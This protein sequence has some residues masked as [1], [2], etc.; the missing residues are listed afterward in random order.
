MMKRKFASEIYWPLAFQT[1]VKS[2]TK[3]FSNFVAFSEKPN[4]TWLY[5]KPSL[6]IR[7][8]SAIFWI[9]L[10]IFRDYALK[11]IFLFYKIENWNFQHLFKIEFLEIK[12]YLIIMSNKSSIN[13]WWRR[14]LLPIGST[15]VRLR[16]S[17]TD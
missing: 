7:T 2:T 17:L 16:R 13:F 10:G 8:A 1:F 9:Y 3:I 15:L 14:Y 11:N 6:K 5:S 4:F 12:L